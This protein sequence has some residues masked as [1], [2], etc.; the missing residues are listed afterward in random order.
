MP[1][2][3]YKMERRLKTMEVRGLEQSGKGLCKAHP[4]KMEQTY[5]RK[6]QGSD[7]KTKNCV[8]LVIV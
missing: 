8:E 5:A 1:G 7:K 4:T 6:W 3:I 2:G